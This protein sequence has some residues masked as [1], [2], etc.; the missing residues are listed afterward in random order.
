MSD[1]RPVLSNEIYGESNL[2]LTGVVHYL[3]EDLEK[4]TDEKWIYFDKQGGGCG[5][6]GAGE[7]FSLDFIKHRVENY[8]EFIPITLRGLGVDFPIKYSISSH[9]DVEDTN[10]MT[11]PAPS[12]SEV[13][14]S[15]VKD[16]YGIV[17]PGEGIFEIGGFRFPW[18]HEV[19]L[20]PVARA[21]ISIGR[22]NSPWSFKF[23]REKD[24]SILNEL[25][26]EWFKNDKCFVDVEIFPKASYALLEVIS[27]TFNPEKISF[28]RKRALPCQLGGLISGLPG[29]GKSMFV[30]FLKNEI[31]RQKIDVLYNTFEYSASSIVDN[32]NQNVPLPQRGLIIFDDIE[33]VIQQRVQ[34]E[35][36]SANNATLSWLLNEL[37]SGDKNVCRLILLITNYNDS[38]DEAMIRAGRLDLHMTFEEPDPAKLL[39]L[40][41]FHTE[42]DIPPALRP[43]IIELMKNKMDVL[44]FGSISLLCRLAYTMTDQY[45]KSIN[46]WE[47]VIDQML[48]MN[49]SSGKSEFGFQVLKKY[50]E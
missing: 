43:K 45:F 20:E 32:A 5:P 28:L 41:E 6:P 44:N 11:S 15:D 24:K 36:F 49:M 18:N 2:H 30:K 16:D 9:C 33:S 35:P 17:S 37:D 13:N 26:A 29:T 19:L 4:A 42:D 38:I 39:H 40:L 1:S 34:G 10:N 22:Y 31:Q 7:N 23:I 25:Y 14:L 47:L 21:S 27:N 46:F 50:E 12:L 8:P 3:L 48:N